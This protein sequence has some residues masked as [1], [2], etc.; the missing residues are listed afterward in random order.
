MKSLVP[1]VM[2]SIVGIYGLVVAV[3]ISQG[4]AP[5]KPYSLYASAVHLAAGMSTGCAGLAAG[6]TIGVVGDAAV[7]RYPF[8]D[9]IFVGMVLMLIFAEV[10]GLYGLIG[11]LLSLSILLY[12]LL[13]D[14]VSLVMNT[15][16]SGLACA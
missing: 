3:L 14:V 2:A 7:R 15:K 16:T 9:R 8:Q 5:D 6:W 13:L 12:N 1:V 11:T 10:L 4:L